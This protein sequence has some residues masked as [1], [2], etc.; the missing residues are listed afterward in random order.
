MLQ[1]IQHRR[2]A[3][4]KG[5]RNDIALLKLCSPVQLSQTVQPVCLPQP[6]S[7]PVFNGEKLTVLGWGAEYWGG[8][9]IT[10]LR[11]VRT[12]YFIIQ[13]CSFFT[14][15]HQFRPLLL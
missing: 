11:E 10:T 1:I 13:V 7:D 6:E 14:H 2:F 8:S 3:L 9:P 12:N 5:V 4:D 15:T